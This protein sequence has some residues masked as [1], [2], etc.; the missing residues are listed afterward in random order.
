MRIERRKFP[1]LYFTKMRCNLD[2]CGWGV[3]VGFFQG[4][5]LDVLHEI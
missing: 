4:Y 1:P 2:V 5:I 3:S